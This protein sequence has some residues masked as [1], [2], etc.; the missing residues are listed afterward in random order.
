MPTLEEFISIIKEYF[1]S[2]WRNLSTNQVDE[3]INGGRGIRS[4]YT[5]V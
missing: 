4:N 1:Q 5:S 2:A 3:Y